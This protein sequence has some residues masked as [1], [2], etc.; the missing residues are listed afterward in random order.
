M[1]SKQKYI[2]DVFT[3]TYKC[4]ILCTPENTENPQTLHPAP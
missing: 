2:N 1:N 4:G 3:Y